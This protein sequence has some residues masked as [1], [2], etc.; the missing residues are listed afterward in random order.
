M[1]SIDSV[2]IG[3][4]SP[5]AATRRMR[6]VTSRRLPSL[7]ERASNEGSIAK[8]EVTVAGIKGEL[9]P[10][11][12]PISTTFPERPSNSFWRSPEKMLDPQ[13]ISIALG[14]TRLSYHLATWP[15]NEITRS[16][17]PTS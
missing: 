15:P 14:S 4:A 16:M 1:Q 5:E 17:K 8:Y 9:V 2:A 10:L 12:K 6:E 13:T 3:S 11:P 7:S